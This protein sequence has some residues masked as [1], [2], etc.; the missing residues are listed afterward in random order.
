MGCP[1]ESVASGRIG[2]AG[3]H[4]HIFDDIPVTAGCASRAASAADD[5]LR[6]QFVDSLRVAFAR[7]LDLERR[8]EERRVGKE[9]VSTC[10]TRWW[11]Y[12]YKKIKIV[13]HVK[14]KCIM[15]RR[16]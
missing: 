3:R 11:P 7:S 5:Q 15:T 10:R 4:Q 9:S 8:S 6:H 1:S 16:L 14:F 12:H 2:A 13:E